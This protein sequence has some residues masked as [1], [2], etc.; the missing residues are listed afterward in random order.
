MTRTLVLGGARSGK[1]AFAETLAENQGKE[2][3]YIAT[4]QAKDTEMAARIKHHQQQRPA[5]WRLVEEPLALGEALLK[6]CAP[7]RVV[8]IDCLTLWLANLL[9]DEKTEYPEIGLIPLPELFHEQRE[10]FLTALTQVTGE[11][12]LVSNEVGLGVVPYG[13]VSRCFVD[14]AGRLNQAVAKHCE[15]VLL[16]AAGLPLVLKGSAC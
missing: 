12:I 1:S 8:L 13:A 4:A 16:V 2:V 3:I 7:D 5:S 14:E 9:F 10:Q 15:N 11:L 6:W